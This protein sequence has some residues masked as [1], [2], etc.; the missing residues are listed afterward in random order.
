MGM[1]KNFQGSPPVLL[2][3]KSNVTSKTRDLPII[4]ILCF[5]ERLENLG[6]VSKNSSLEIYGLKEVINNEC[7]QKSKKRDE[8]KS[9]NY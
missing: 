9:P 7:H 6:F 1:G 3:G 5:S 2:V 8:K 4:G